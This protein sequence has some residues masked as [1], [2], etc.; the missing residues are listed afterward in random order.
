MVFFD[1]YILY[2]SDCLVLLSILLK[3]PLQSV[4]LSYC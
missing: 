2:V 1:S 4:Y 3:I